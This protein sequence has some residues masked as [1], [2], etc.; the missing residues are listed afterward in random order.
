MYLFIFMVLAGCSFDKDLNKANKHMHRSSHE[1]LVQGFE[2]PKR[3]QE[4]RPDIVMKLLSPLRG[5]SVIDIGVG[6]GYFTKYLLKSGASVTGA[7]VDDKFLKIVSEKFSSKKYPL[8]RTLKI[9]YND[10]KM[11]EEFYDMA[12][13]S[14]TYHHIENRVDYLRKVLLGLRPAGRFVVFDYKKNLNVAHSGPPQE[15]RIHHDLVVEELKK[16]GFQSI[17]LNISDFENH[18]LIVARK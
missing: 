3:D 17:I 11:E 2:D 15:M 8:F 4:Q 6:S 5:L 9:D 18:Y 16:A 7:D 12:F 13:T 1:E 14:N 10:P